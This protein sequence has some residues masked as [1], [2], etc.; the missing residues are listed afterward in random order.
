MYNSVIRNILYIQMIFGDRY[1]MYA[2]IL[3]TNPNTERNT[4]LNQF[5]PHTLPLDYP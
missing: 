3:Q 1:H 4:E 2:N 5:I